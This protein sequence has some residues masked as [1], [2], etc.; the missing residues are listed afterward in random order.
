MCIVLPGLSFVV[1]SKESSKLFSFSQISNAHGFTRVVLRQLLNQELTKFEF[2]HFYYVKVQHNSNK[3]SSNIQQQHS[4]SR[5]T[6]NADQRKSNSAEKI[7]T[8]FIFSLRMEAALSKFMSSVFPL[9]YKS[10]FC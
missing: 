8:N 9:N 2:S 5:K 6:N 3:N 7:N 1:L 4:A 10:C